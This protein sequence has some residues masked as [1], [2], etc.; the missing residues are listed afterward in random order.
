[1]QGQIQRCGC[2]VDLV[3]GGIMYFG[4]KLRL[5]WMGLIFFSYIVLDIYCIVYIFFGL[6]ISF[7][8]VKESKYF[9]CQCLVI[10]ENEFCFKIVN[11]FMLFG[12]WYSIRVRIRQDWFWS[13]DLLYFCNIIVYM[14]RMIVCVVVVLGQVVIL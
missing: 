9:V 14:L 1:M 4:L 10:L 11:I 2:L 13:L 12:R 5:F 6:K 8:W 3:V 7:V